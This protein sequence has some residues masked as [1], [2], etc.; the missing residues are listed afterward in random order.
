MLRMTLDISRHQMEYRMLAYTLSCQ[1]ALFWST[2][3]ALTV[4]SGAN[5][6]QFS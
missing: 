5:A 6:D 2:R 1:V 3:M 4:K